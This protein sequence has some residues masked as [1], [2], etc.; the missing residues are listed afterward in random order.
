M[1]LTKAGGI[2]GHKAFIIHR[3]TEVARV[4]VGNY[5]PGVARCGKKLP[6]KFILSDLVRAG[7]F[8][9]TIYRLPKGYVCH[10]DSD[11]IRNDR[12]HKD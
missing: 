4:C 6:N 1:R 5:V 7:Y 8:D 3:D 10:R 9:H 12:L 11:I 2:A